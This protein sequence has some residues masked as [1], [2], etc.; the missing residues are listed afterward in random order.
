MPEF[1]TDL[2]HPR[3]PDPPRLFLY[4][5]SRL[6]ALIGELRSRSGASPATLHGATHEAVQYVRELLAHVTAASGNI[7]FPEID[8]LR[9]YHLDSYSVAEEFESVHHTVLSSRAFLLTMPAFLSD[10]TALAPPDAGLV[11]DL[12]ACVRGM[13]AAITEVDRVIE[14]AERVSVA[15]YLALLGAGDSQP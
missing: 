10:A 13:C 5:A 9:R 4:Y 7:S 8:L 3:N 12:K 14:P 2:H 11:Q 1:L 6:E 15:A